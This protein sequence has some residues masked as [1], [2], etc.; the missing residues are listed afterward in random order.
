M[1]VKAAQLIWKIRWALTPFAK[2]FLDITVSLVALI[3]ISPL[4][5]LV[6]I[7]IRLESKG[8]VIFQQTRIGLNGVPFTMLKFRSMSCDAQSQRAAL[9]QN[10]EMSSYVT[11]KIKR[12]PRITRI[13]ALIRK[14]S[15]DELPQ[16]INVIK[17]DM[18]LVGPRPP[19]SS[20]VNKYS[21]ADRSRLA[22]VPGITC[23]W[24]ISGRSE[25]P[26]EQQV[27]LDIQYIEKQSMWFDLFILLK[28]IPAV[29]KAR[30]AY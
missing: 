17:G 29:I 5:I 19:L 12:D 10:N 9:E 13:G 8:S 18:S 27:K 14:T 6:A 26:F 1:R 20:E 4:L 25:I 16:L 3:L 15:I 7:L 22:V 30:G 2:R 21:R 28:T 23:L 11:F 24:Q